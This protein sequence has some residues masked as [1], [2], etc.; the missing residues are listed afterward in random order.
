VIVE[1]LVSKETEFSVGDVEKKYSCIISAVIKNGL[2]SLPNKND[3]IK[4]GDRIIFTINKKDTGRIIH[5][6][7]KEILL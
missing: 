5:A 1:L 7:S 3:I 4:K 6:L 2:T